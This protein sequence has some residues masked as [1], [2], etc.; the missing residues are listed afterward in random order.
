[1]KIL[2][3]ILG[4]LLVLM[5]VVLLLTTPIG[6]LFVGIGSGCLIYS[7]KKEPVPERYHYETKK[8]L[9][10]QNIDE[11][12]E[13]MEDSRELNEDYMRPKNELLEGFSGEKIF[14]YEILPIFAQTKGN[15][16]YSCGI[17]LGHID[18]E[19]EPGETIKVMLCGGEYK[20]VGEEDISTGKDEPW[21]YV[22]ITKK[23]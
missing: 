23:A 5:G 1:M 15:E 19:L 14:K 18:R 21:L 11:F 10:P 8:L 2:Y 20:F 9:D 17:H 4:V 16:V 3:R 6:L 12:F 7:F 22:E 13:E